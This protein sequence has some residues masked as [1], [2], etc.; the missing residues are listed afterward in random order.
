MIALAISLAHWLLIYISMSVSFSEDHR[1]ECQK[2]AAL[3]ACLNPKERD[4]V[5]Q[6]NA[7]RNP[8]LFGRN[9]PEAD[10]MTESPRQL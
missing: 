9:T 3:R 7:Q 5:G 4:S 6:N 8:L 2:Q 10:D 1:T